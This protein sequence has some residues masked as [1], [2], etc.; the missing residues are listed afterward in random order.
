MLLHLWYLHPVG[1]SVGLLGCSVAEIYH[2]LV[3]SCRELSLS[4]FWR[5]LIYVVNSCFIRY[6]SFMRADKK[7]L[8]THCNFCTLLLS[9]QVA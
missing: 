8:V 4:L 5:E 7:D 9:A 2:F 1:L 6:V 3:V